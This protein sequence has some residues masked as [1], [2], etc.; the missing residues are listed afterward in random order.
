MYH[1]LALL[2]GAVIA[3]M[4]ALNGGLTGYYGVFMAAVI[5]HIIG[6]LF[7]LALMKAAGKKCRL[8]KGIPAWL[9][10]GGAMGV[11]T[12]VFNNFAFGKIS[13]TSIVALGLFGQTAASIILD[14]SGL[15]GMKKYPFKKSSLACLILSSAGI[16][17]MLDHSADAALY[18]V[19][20]SVAA[21]VS[22]VLSRTVNAGLAGKTGELQSSLINHI[23]GLWVAVIFLCIFGRNE[24]MAF[25]AVIGEWWI[26]LGGTLGVAV[27]LLFNITVPK[28]PAF[29]LTLLTF[30]GQIFSGIV[31]DLLAEHPYSQET[32]FGGILVAGGVFVN[33]L[34]ERSGSSAD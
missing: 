26:Y 5:I 30:V 24:L 8:E 9:F 7:A 16:L 1:L 20:F 22:V 10:T 32:L 6:I 29:Q 13:L 28:V 18:A 15:F 34:W 3:V 33:L 21:G 12:T 27:V 19:L 4:V 17:I 31:M 11:L 25:H 2:T 23:T 14:I